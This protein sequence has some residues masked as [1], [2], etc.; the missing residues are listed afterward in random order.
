MAPRQPTNS[1]PPGYV[2]LPPEIFIEVDEDEQTLILDNGGQALYRKDQLARVFNDGD[3]ENCDDDGN[4]VDGLVIK[5]AR[6]IPA[7]IVTVKSTVEI[8]E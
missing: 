7:G 5:F 3:H 8:S 6:Y 2:E 1:R 4:R